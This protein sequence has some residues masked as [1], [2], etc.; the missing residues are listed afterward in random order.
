MQNGQA[1]VDYVEQQLQQLRPQ[2]SPV[3]AFPPQ[4]E[5]GDWGVPRGPP[6]LAFAGG[7][8]P[9]Q[10]PAPVQLRTD[11]ENVMVRRCCF[12]ALPPSQLLVSCG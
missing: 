10:L 6:L 9:I 11:K 5:R 2:H 7:P 1:P 4:Q 12:L 3:Q 8:A